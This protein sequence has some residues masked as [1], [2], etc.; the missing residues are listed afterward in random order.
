MTRKSPELGSIQVT[1]SPSP[2][3]AA[4]G[5]GLPFKAAFKANCR[6]QTG[7]AAIFGLKQPSNHDYETLYLAL[8]LGWKT[9]K[10]GVAA[11]YMDTN[12]KF[13]VRATVEAPRR[14]SWQATLLLACT[15]YQNSSLNGYGN[16]DTAHLSVAGSLRGRSVY[17][18]ASRQLQQ[19]VYPGFGIFP[20]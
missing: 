14:S 10:M 19:G 5:R 8:V 9:L 2:R 20:E 15:A 12:G 18:T 3:G 4:H 17:I 7:A 16:S 13:Q 6:V 11:S 1:L